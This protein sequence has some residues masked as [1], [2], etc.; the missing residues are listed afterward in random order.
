MDDFSLPSSP[1][2]TQKVSLAEGYIDLD[3]NRRAI[4]NPAAT[5]LFQVDESHIENVLKG[6]LLIVNCSSRPRPGDVLKVDIEGEYKIR[7]LI[8]N[9]GKLFL[10]TDDNAIPPYPTDET[11]GFCCGV[12]TGLYRSS[13]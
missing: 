5:H 3:L 9:A 2:N 8:R 1:D 4:Q 6:D 7:R 13:V 10:V 12:V 11:G